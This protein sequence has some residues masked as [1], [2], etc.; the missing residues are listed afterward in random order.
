MKIA[1]ENKKGSYRK[2]KDPNGKKWKIRMNFDYGRISGTKAV[3]GENVD[4]YI[5]MD[6]DAKMVYV[7]H[8]RDPFNDGR[9][10]EDKCFV[11][12]PNREE[13]IKAYL[14]QYDDPRFLGP[15][16]EF[17]IDQFKEA[18]KEKKGKM[19]YRSPDL[20]EPQ[21]KGYLIKRH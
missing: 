13:V 17:T 2:G 14:S 5:G 9:Y 19:L 21:R 12:F 7:V 16:S 3:D 20:I 11:F 4:A 18:L 15:I 6:D 10:D 1:I 8:Q